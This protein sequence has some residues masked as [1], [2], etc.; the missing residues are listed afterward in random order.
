MRKIHINK[1]E[2]SWKVGKRF[3]EIRSPSNNKII[4]EKWE[5]LQKTKEQYYKDSEI[6]GTTLWEDWKHG[7]F[8]G[9]EFLEYV[10][11]KNWTPNSITPQKIKDFIKLK[12][13]ETVNI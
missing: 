4:A 1:N 8:S 13:T 3:V 10:G 11:D 6:V 2:W 7:W 9:E 12:I 5:V